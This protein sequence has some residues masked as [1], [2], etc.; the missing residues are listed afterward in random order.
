[1]VYGGGLSRAAGS[2]LQLSVSSTPPVVGAGQA[3]TI[4]F[5]GA[6]PS[7]IGVLSSGLPE[8]SVL[9][10][11]VLDSNNDPLAGVPISFFVNGVGGEQIT[12]SEAVTDENGMATTTV[13]SG[14][15]AAPVQVSA[16]VDR[17]GDG[18]FD[19]VTQSTAVNVVGAPPA[20]DR[21]SMASEFVNVSG[22][23]FFGIDNQITAFLN[24]RFGNAGAAG[25]GGELHHQR[26][27]HLRPGA[28]R[29]LRP[30]DRNAAHRGRRSRQRHRDHPRHHARR[31]AVHRRQRQR[32]A[33]CRRDLHRHSRAVHRRERQRPLRSGQSGRAL[34]RH[35]RQRSLG[36]R[37]G[38]GAV[39]QQR[40]H[41]AHHPGHLLRRHPGLP[42]A[43]ELQHR[44][45]RIAEL[46]ADR[47]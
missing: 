17:N 34:R 19:I 39:G 41:L 15:R 25:H 7:T 20:Y 40:P 16:A 24:D 8:Q 31:G 2:T 33:R 32:Q 13:K 1:M 43:L 36:R 21:L 22:R 42:A 4:I 45:R 18:S 28:H 35:Q 14:T 30:G 10:F 11:S 44:R 9:T 23:V 3:Q 26:R 6:A 29:R 38:T 5:E 37:P 12:P 46:H 47:R 27:Q